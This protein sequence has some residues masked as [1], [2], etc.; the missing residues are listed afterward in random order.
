MSYLI[1][2]LVE[3]RRRLWSTIREVFSYHNTTCMHVVTKVLNLNELITL[4]FPPIKSKNEA[5]QT[6]NPS[7]LDLE[8]NRRV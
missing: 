2:G 8:R 1:L 4:N 5:H 3:R 7:K 6:L